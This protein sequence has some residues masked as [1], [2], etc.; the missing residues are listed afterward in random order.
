M[1]SRGKYILL[2]E[3]DSVTAIQEKMILEKQG[4]TVKTVSSGEDAV[5]GVDYDQF[6]LILMDIDLGLGKMN[7]TP[8]PDTID[9]V[10]SP[11]PELIFRFPSEV[12]EQ[13]LL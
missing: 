12:F 4:L 1:N 11:H 10:R 2:V 7:G 13:T 3:N 9:I 8:I 6:D 5:Y